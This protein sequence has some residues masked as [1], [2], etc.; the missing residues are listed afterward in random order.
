MEMPAAFVLALDGVRREHAA[1]L[2][3]APVVPHTERPRRTRRVRAALARGL[4]RAA[5]VIEPAC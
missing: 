2:P 3:G 4:I 1:A 5:H